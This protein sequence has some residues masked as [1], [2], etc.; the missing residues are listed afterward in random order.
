MED[1][2]Q[3]EDPQKEYLIQGYETEVEN[4]IRT[5]LRERGVQPLAVEAELS[6]DDLSVRQIRLEVGAEA[7]NILYE[8]EIQEHQEQLKKEMEEL[9][10]ELS[11]VYQVSCDHIDVT[12]QG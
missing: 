5:F 4:Q 8:S 1:R 12:I 6:E 10:K 9:K 2:Y 3:M 11:E 7:E